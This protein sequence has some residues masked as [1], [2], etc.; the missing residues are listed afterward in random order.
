MRVQP[1]PTP[2]R[3][4]LLA[5]F[6]ASVLAVPFAAAP[7]ERSV[8]GSSGE[9]FR[10]LA[11]TYGELF[12]GGAQAEASSAVLALDV[13]ESDGTT[14]RLLVPGTEGFEDDSSP[15]LVYDEVSQVVHLVWETHANFIHPVLRLA[16]YGDGGWAEPIEIIGDAFAAKTHP[17]LLVTHDSV[18]TS[19]AGDA[20]A[21]APEEASAASSRRTILHLVWA[22]ERSGGPFEV[23]Y[24]PILLADGGSSAA[25]P[26]ISLDALPGLA[27][28]AGAAIDPSAEGL[29]HLRAG[30]DGR[31]VVVAFPSAG[32]GRITAVR[33]DILPV[34]LARLGEG[35]RAHII[36]AGFRGGGD[37]LRRI[38]DGARAHI[39][40]A[41]VRLSFH[42]EVVRSIADSARAHIIDA[43][44]RGEV[45]VRRI[46]DGARAHIIDAGVKFS[47]RGLRRAARSSAATQLV[48]LPLQSGLESEHVV[49]LGVSSSVAAPEGVGASARL[50]GS[51]SGTSFILSWRDGEQL[52]YRESRNGGEWSEARVIRLSPTLSADDAYAA[53]ER[54]VSSF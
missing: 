35:A 42:E 21:E 51:P 33:L 34:E 46:A 40:D 11:G 9:L 10:V 48:E 18:P 22:Q 16:S 54:R 27:P 44:A 4:T 23:L 6:L 29:M 5:A 24:S 25:P 15:A 14:L 38:A 39:I 49:R 30:E 52:T 37:E 20:P 26:V 7:L 19:Q 45:D 28:S 43:G 8:I 53:L 47:D 36:D 41:G 50:F 12:P 13:A 32:T 3:R 2:A 31:T 1:L 17:A